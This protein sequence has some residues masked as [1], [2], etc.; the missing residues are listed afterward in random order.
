MTTQNEATVAQTTPPISCEEII[1]PQSAPTQIGEFLILSKL[2]EGSFGQVYLARQISLG[3]EV[4][5]KVTRPASNDL[6]GSS[7]PSQPFGTTPS[8]ARARNEGKLLAGLEHDNIVKVFS[9]FHDVESGARGLCLQYVP[10]ADLGA[11]IRQV[12][13]NKQTPESGTAILSALDATQRGEARFDPSSLRD[14]ESLA[15][16]T[17][18]QAICRIGARL[19]EALAFAHTRGILHC[20][21][22]PGNILLTPYGRPMLADFNV[23]FDRVRHNPAAGGI[24]GTISYMA[25]EHRAAVFGQKSGRVDERCD[26]Y[27]LGLVLHELATG[28]RLPPAKTE[29]ATEAIPVLDKVPR[30]LAA[31][32]RRCLDSAPANRYQSATELAIALNAAW[33]LLAARRSL[34][35]PIRAARWVSENPIAALT[36]AAILPH[37]PA[38]IV[39][40][41]YNAVQIEL[42]DAQHRVFLVL[43]LVYNLI[44]YVGCAGTAAYL[45]WKVKQGLVGL[46]F[47]PGPAVDELRRRVLCLGW[48]AVALGSLGWF[49]GGIIFPLVIDLVAGG[50]DWQMYAHYLVSFTLAGLIAV[51]FSYLSIQAVVLRALLPNLGNPDRYTPVGMWAE[52]KPMT[53]AFGP[54]LMLASAVPLT[55]AVLLITLTDGVM[56]LG[57]RLLVAGLIGVG[58]MG[59]GIAERL[60][61]RLRLL[62]EVWHRE[63]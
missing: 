51:V 38:T 33:Q 16:D 15:G 57:F 36:L 50:F 19:A 37:V 44:A 6:E 42:N 60:T 29:D 54:F 62:A 34:P 32:I 49:S 61:A 14:R 55:G 26:I 4:A 52:V 12:Y 5:L 46:I 21:I 58:V 48:W 7:A 20:D 28:K 23:A 40:I 10:G 9:E 45:I 35:P 39:N 47:A 24:G 53:L 27:S 41:G 18:P 13:A 59:V 2:G 22:K 56:T 17:F 3:R 30:E 8:D 25:P 63:P 43:I 31:V 11:I 1:I